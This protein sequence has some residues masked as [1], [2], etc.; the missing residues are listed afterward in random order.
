MS[1]SHSSVIWSSQHS[2]QRPLYDSLSSSETS[3]QTQ[4]VNAY[5]EQH[6]IFYM[7]DYLVKKLLR[8]T[9]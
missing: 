1:S 5:R 8:K 6:K 7:F 4:Q 3:P 9:R 2:Q